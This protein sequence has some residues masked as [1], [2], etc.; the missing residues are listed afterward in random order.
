MA[1]KKQSS[2][3]GTVSKIL[4]SYVEAASVLPNAKYI[5]VHNGEKQIYSPNTAE[6]RKKLTE[7]LGKPRVYDYRGKNRRTWLDSRIY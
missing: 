5:S 6:N 3:K 1:K 7:K 2:K 4:N